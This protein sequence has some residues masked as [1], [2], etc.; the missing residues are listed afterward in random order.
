M[1]S[2]RQRVV[3]ALQPPRPWEVPLVGLCGRLAAVVLWGCR[4]GCR[5]KRRRRGTRSGCKRLQ[6][7]S[8]CAGGAPTRWV[9]RGHNVY[10]YVYV[11]VYVRVCACACACLAKGMCG[12]KEVGVC[13]CRA[14]GG[15]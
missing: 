9:W 6:V 1:V 4:R 8:A 13:V 14:R 10:V 2:R 7:V 5:R 3:S 11:Y 12:S 15:L